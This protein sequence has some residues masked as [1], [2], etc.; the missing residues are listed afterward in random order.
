M[1]I[2]GAGLAGL[3]AARS[4]A[5]AGTAVRLLDKSTG[6]GGRLATRRIGD[7][8]LDHG[9]QFFTVRSDTFSALTD[10]WR[11]EGAGIE[12]WSLGFAQAGDVR[13]GPAG[14]AS[15]AGDGHPRYVLRGGMNAMAKHLA[16]GLDIV[17]GARATAAWVHDGRWLVAVGGATGAV[18]HRTRTLVCACPVPQALEVIA[19]GDTTLSCEAL[20]ALRSV[21]YDPCLAL[22]T[23]LDRR[24]DA[25]P[26]PGGV[27]FASGPVRWLADNGRKPVSRIPAV[28]VHASGAWSRDWCDAGEEDIAATLGAWLHPWIAP[29]T[30]VDRQIMRWRYAQPTDLLD[31]R[32]L[33]T[34][35]DG[36]P[37]HVAGDA[38]G[39]ARV[40]GAAL[41]GL[42]VAD[43]VLANG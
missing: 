16:R 6:P 19:R 14:V 31:R 2:V 17:T 39:H 20:D 27:Q 40:E 28:T 18:V 21:G 29:A 36:A 42:A 30:V 37:L 26:H 11:G 1:L 8:T 25:L 33:S 41:S 34:A 23:V 5:A 13:D 35:V 15:S 4:L 7:A 10:R 43:A 32:L 38:F 12:Q 24:P 9:A 22:L 3:V